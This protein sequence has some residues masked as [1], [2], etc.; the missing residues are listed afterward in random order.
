[1]ID[2]TGMI[3]VDKDIPNASL[4]KGAHQISSLDT[5]SSRRCLI[6]RNASMILTMF[7]RTLLPEVFAVVPC[8]CCY[9]TSWGA[10]WGGALT[11]PWYWPGAAN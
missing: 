8:I 2:V 7:P 10:P 9:W 3:I 1:M 11:L 5:M 6:I 4:L